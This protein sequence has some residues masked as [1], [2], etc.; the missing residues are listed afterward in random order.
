M[1]DDSVNLAS[2]LARQARE[3]PDAPAILRGGASLGFRE[4]DRHVW[5]AATWLARQGIRPADRVGL[6][7]DGELAHLIAIYALARLGASA[8]ALPLSE[9][10]PVR[11]RLA[12]EG[13]CECV[14]TDRARALADCG[15][16]V[17]GFDARAVC[18]PGAP[19]DP[20]VE[21]ARPTAPW[22]LMMGSG[23]TGRSKRMA[24]GHGQWLARLAAQRALLPI[25]PGDRVVGLSPLS[26]ATTKHR[27][28]E[29]H[30][31]GAAVVLFDR[32]REPLRDVCRRLGVT[33][34]HAS[35]VHAEALLAD[36]PRAPR[37]ML[38]GVKVLRVGNTTVTERLRARIRATLTPNLYVAYSTNE[39]GPLTVAPPADGLALPGT[40]G[41]PAAPV[42]IEVV[43]DDGRPCPAGRVGR[44]RVRGPGVI[45]GYEDDPTASARAFADGAFLPGDLAEWAPDGQLVHH[46]RADDLMIFQGVNI[47]PGEIE[48]AM[49]E[50]PAVGD[51]A[52]FPVDSD[53][54][55]H[56]PACAVTLREGAAAD[57]ATLA[58]YAQSQLGSHAPHAVLILPSLPRTAN[59][60][61][62]RAD[63][64]GLARA[65]LNGPTP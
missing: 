51:V 28:L 47:E 17:L 44:V 56:V 46:G 14:L 27:Y 7:L 3:R 2:A 38:A 26:F 52:A 36:A 40:V 33:V 1:R 43:D 64:A 61:L 32:A 18:A 13:R 21:V 63:L 60:K 9:P 57:E 4:L 10:P 23:T 31:C 48:T 5:A 35:P 54:L 22:L 50:H 8:L 15:P 6:S 55:R 12:R 37:P 34:V 62:R 45:D 16:P 24:I 59:G 39:A 30:A 58:R 25:G 19:I 29:A 11:R 20:G 65:R 42:E 49:R 41:R 53:V